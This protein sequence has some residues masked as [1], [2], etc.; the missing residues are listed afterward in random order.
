MSVSSLLPSRQD[1]VAADVEELQLAYGAD[2]ITEAG[3]CLRLPQ[4][5]IVSAQVLFHRFYTVTSLKAHGHVWTAAAALLVACKSEEQQRR[6]RDVANV[7]HYCF[8]ARERVGAAG[9]DGRPRPLDYYGEPGYEWKRTVIAAERHL[10]KELGFQVRVDH[11]HKFVLVFMNTMRDAAG[12]AGGWADDAAWRG[13]LQAAWNYASDALRARL[14]VVEAP[15]AVACACIA[16]AADR[17]GRPLPAGWAGVFGADEPRCRRIAAA[18]RRVYGL[19]V[20][21]GRFEDVALCGVAAAC[22]ARASPGG[23]E[24]G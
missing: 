11:P 22:A 15:E 3:R 13:V 17:C 6:V 19:G 21:A 20:T 12:A 23:A 10:L 2:L 18:I 9:A 14:P 1:G 4:V 16:L 5:V 24:P 8:C 7:V